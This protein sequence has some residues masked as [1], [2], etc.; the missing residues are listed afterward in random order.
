MVGVRTAAA[1]VTIIADSAGLLGVADVL[2]RSPARLQRPRRPDPAKLPPKRATGLGLVE[3]ADVPRRPWRTA[4]GAD[5]TAGPVPDR[6]RA[7]EQPVRQ[8]RDDEHGHH[9]GQPD[10]G[11][12]NVRHRRAFPPRVPVRE[13]VD[14]WSRCR[15]QGHLWDSYYGLEPGTLQVP[16]WEL[17]SSNLYTNDPSC[18]MLYL[19]AEATCSSGPSTWPVTCGN[20]NTRRHLANSQNANLTPVDQDATSTLRPAT[21]PGSG[22]GEQPRQAR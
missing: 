21:L 17:H 10:P 1:T 12:L 5:M 16:Y 2:H 18:D 6:P 19:V 11:R 13:R 3:R 20:R 15:R 8:E 14:G 4:V 7:L 9:G 22:G